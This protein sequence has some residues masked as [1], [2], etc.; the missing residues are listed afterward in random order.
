M[1]QRAASRLA[2]AIG[3]ICAACVIASLVLLVLD[4]KAIN[5]PYT[6]QAPWIANAIVVGALGVLIVTRR[7]RNP[8]G[9]LLLA[10]ALGNATNVLAY[11]IAIHGLLAGASAHGWV[12]WPTW[13]YS[14]TGGIG[15]FLLVFL[16]FFFP[17]GKLPTPRWRW[18]AWVSFAVSL[19]LAAGSMISPA[20][21]SYLR[22]SPTSPT[23]SS[24]RRLAD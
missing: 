9:W 24:C 3:V 2:L 13:F 17:N 6:S 22:D 8:I 5:S 16:V 1:S 18:V 20:Q 10:I 4:W 23:R 12:E 14:Q 19:V 21:H 7:A 11:F 15:A